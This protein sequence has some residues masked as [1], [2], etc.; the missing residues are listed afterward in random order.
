M[1]SLTRKTDYAIVAMADLARRGASRT[2]AREVAESTKV[3]LPVLTNILHKLLHHGLVT[4]TMGAKG[5]YCIAKPPDQINL[6]DMIDAIEGSF[7]LTVCCE[8]ELAQTDDPCELEEN[9]RVK[10]PVRRVHSSLRNFLRQVTLAQIAFD[11][12]QIGMALTAGTGQGERLPVM[13][14]N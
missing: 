7:K 5:G 13:T 8:S 2:S 9:C 10:G 11:S 12:V 1:L 14:P 4:S 6:A 3:P